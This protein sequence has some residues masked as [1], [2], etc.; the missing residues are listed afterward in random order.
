MTRSSYR[1]IDKDQPHFL[2]FTVVEWLP[3]FTNPAIVDI[4]LESLRFLQKE[5]AFVIYTYVILENHIHIVASCGDLGKT[6][7][8]FKSFTATQITKYL[9]ENGSQNLLRILQ[10]AKLGYKTNRNIRY[11]RK[12]A[13]LSGFR[14]K[15]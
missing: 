2:T 8:E 6:V 12:E 4:I 9:D 15:I 3:L 13:T 11:G 7:K 14:R 10:R 1:F 5:R